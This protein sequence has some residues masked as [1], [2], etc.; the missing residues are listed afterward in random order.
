MGERLRSFIFAI[1]VAIGIS[2]INTSFAKQPIELFWED[3]VP[4]NYTMPPVQMEHTGS[5]LQVAPNAPLVYKY[6]DKNVKVPGFVVPLETNQDNLVTEF[7]LVPY[8]G[9]CIHVPPPPS[10]QIIYVNFSDGV[11][12]DSLYDA[13]WVEGILSTERWES[14]IASVGYR[15]KGSRVSLFDE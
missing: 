13:V 11:P 2:A 7:L 10:N 6:N 15:L 8:F 4:E 5:M 12:I 1:V 9:A 14:E 3:L